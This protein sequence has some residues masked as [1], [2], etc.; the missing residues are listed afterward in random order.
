MEGGGFEVGNQRSRRWMGRGG[1]WGVETGDS[2]GEEN[3]RG[4]GDVS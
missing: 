2:S 3:L 1:K 4:R